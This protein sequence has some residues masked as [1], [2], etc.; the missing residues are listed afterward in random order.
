MWYRIARSYCKRLSRVSSLVR[1]DGHTAKVT[2]TKTDRAEL[3]VARDHD[4]ASNTGL[5]K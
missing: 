4:E 5:N 1:V 2:E 3:V